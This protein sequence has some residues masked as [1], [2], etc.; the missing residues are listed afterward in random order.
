MELHKVLWLQRDF[1]S[2][3]NLKY[4]DKNIYYSYPQDYLEL[5]SSLFRLSGI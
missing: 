5:I 4:Y 1:V 3:P 2:M